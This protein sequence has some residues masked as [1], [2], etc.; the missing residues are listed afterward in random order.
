MS[1]SE[2]SKQIYS[3]GMFQVQCGPNYPKNEFVVYL[4]S[5]FHWVSIIY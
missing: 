4:K 3:K 1:I 5:K 2:N